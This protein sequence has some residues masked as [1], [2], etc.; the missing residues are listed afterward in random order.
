MTLLVKS[1]FRSFE[2]FIQPKTL[3]MVVLVLITTLD[4]IHAEPLEV[5]I[6]I[7]L[8][9]YFGELSIFWIEG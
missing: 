7:A 1:L 8:H 5:D 2:L 9:L 6:E 3:S 4:F